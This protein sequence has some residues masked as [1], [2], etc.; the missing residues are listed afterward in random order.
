MSAEP[1]PAAPVRPV[2]H[3]VPP[4]VPDVGHHQEGAIGL[5]F[6]FITVPQGRWMTSR[7][8]GLAVACAWATMGRRKLPTAVLPNPPRK[9][10]RKILEVLMF[11]I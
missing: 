11:M 9:V 1:T 5:S 6:G 10:R 4:A 7:R 8:C 2:L 3:E